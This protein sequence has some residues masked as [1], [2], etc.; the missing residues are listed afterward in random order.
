LAFFCFSITIRMMNIK[1]PIILAIETATPACSAALIMGERVL[2]RFEVTQNQHIQLILPMIESLLFEAKVT[3]HDIT[4]IAVGRGPG[5]F[6]GVRIALSVAKGLGYGLHLPIYPISTLEALAYQVKETGEE[7]SIIVPAIDARMGEIYVAVY[8]I[9]S[10][11]LNSLQEEHICSPTNFINNMNFPGEKIVTI[12]S[13]WESPVLAN[14]YP[15]AK[16]IGL[17]AYEQIEK[18]ITGDTAMNVLPVYLRDKVAEY[19]KMKI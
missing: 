7:N 8:Q 1:P 19:P 13:G 14:G 9:K 2:S 12:G 18:G 5:S 6:T 3:L 17:I 10:K 11:K 4:A 15:R 16:H